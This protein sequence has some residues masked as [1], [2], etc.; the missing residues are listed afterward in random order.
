MFKVLEHFRYI[1]KNNFLNAKKNI[2]IIKKVIV[3]H[4]YNII[5]CH[6]EYLPNPKCCCCDKK[7]EF[8]LKKS[9]IS[10]LFSSSF[11]K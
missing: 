6:N 11:D 2:L 9:K 3:D 10:K 4:K 7:M 5:D 8:C 1:K